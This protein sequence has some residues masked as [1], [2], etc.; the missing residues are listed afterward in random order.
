MFR[1]IRKTAFKTYLRVC[2]KDVWVRNDKLKDVKAKANVL[3]N[4]GCL[5]AICVSIIILIN[6]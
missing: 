5:T 3:L 4:I 2:G 1:I 6:K